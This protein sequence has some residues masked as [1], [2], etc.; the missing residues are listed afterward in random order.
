MFSILFFS[1]IFQ[2]SK[3]NKL[4]NAGANRRG[5]KVLLRHF[6]WCQNVATRF[7]LFPRS[8]FTLLANQFHTQTNQFH[9]QTNQ[10]STGAL[11]D[12]PLCVL[13]NGVRR[14][15]GRRNGAADSGCPVRAARARRHRFRPV[16]AGPAAATTATIWGSVSYSNFVGRMLKIP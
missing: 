15:G 9:T 7:Y 11:Q 2:S 6:V 13:F 1:T 5:R 4:V 3:N 8:S 10:Q 12:G 14:N 16:F